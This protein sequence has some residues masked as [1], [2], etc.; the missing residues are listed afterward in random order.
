MSASTKNY[1]SCTQVGAA[2]DTRQSFRVSDMAGE[3]KASGKTKLTDRKTGH[4]RE[5]ARD[6]WN[7]ENGPKQKTHSFGA[8]KRK[9][10]ITRRPI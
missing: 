8:D 3:A 7:H 2:E 6:A 5:S 10:R 4:A 1:I 9:S